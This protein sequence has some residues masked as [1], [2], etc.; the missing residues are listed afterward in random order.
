MLKFFSN[1]AINQAWAVF[2]E[3]T[4]LVKGLKTLGSECSN[5][6]TPDDST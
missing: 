1:G 5:P 2:F 6:D 4:P 3:L